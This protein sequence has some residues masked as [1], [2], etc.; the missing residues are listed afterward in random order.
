MIIRYKLSKP[1]AQILS[2]KKRFKVVC[3]G[4]RFGKSWLSGAAILEQVVNHPK[5]V[6]WY[7]APTLGMAKKIMWNS[8]LNEHIP[9]EYIAEKNKLD[10]TIRFK[11]GSIL[12]VLSSDNPDSLR[13]S[14]VD[15]MILDECCE[16]K[17]GT[18]DVLR[19]VLSDKYVQGRALFVSTPNGHNWFYHLYQKGVENPDEYD[20]F[21]FTTIEGGNVDDAEIES[22]RRDMSPKMFAQEY[23]ASFE[24]LSNRV[25]ENYSKSQNT[26]P[27]NDRWGMRG[28]I[29]VGIDFN[30]N[31]MTAAIAVENGKDI[32][33][34]DE[35]V[36]PNSSTQ[37]LC[38]LIKRKY[39]GVAVN[40][41][42]DP[43]GNKRQT[44]AVVGVTDFSILKANKFK[45]H[46]PR[47][48][49][50]SR[51]KFNAFNTALL[52]ANGER[53]LFIAEGRCPKLRAALDGYCYKADGESTDK[54]QGYD[55]ITDAAAY[56]VAYKKP[57]RRT[58]GLNKPRVF[59]Y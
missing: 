4:R 25:Y 55:H 35:I 33:F 34:F 21:Q 43:T 22:S 50:P 44:S 38:N 2:S 54:S 45:V 40:V 59:G 28:E 31:P 20:V 24:T 19:P 6:V 30:V 7:V 8:W 26:C 57:I 17:E 48:P 46:A 36:E 49:Y 15:L 56:L 42:P 51:D 13:G 12:Y 9:Q 14:G 3:A 11:N 53:H 47:A 58:T 23:L 16:M 39:P 1:Q 37:H 32:I 10:M 27:L 41:Y 5:S 52:N 18:Y 29:H